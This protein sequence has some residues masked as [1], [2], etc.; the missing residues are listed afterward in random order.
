VHFGSYVSK[1]S[2]FGLYV[3][4]CKKSL[5]KIT[6]FGLYIQNVKEREKHISVH[7]FR[8]YA[9]LHEYNFQKYL[10]LD[11]NS[12]T[13]LRGIFIEMGGLGSN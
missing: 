2:V 6:H 9:F 12:K 8:N 11:F 7:L 13:Y 5:T 10:I 1:L 3:S 4:K